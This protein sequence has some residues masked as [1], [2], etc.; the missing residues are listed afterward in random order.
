MRALVNPGTP[1][2]AATAT[3]THAVRKDIIEILDMKGCEVVYTSPDR[4]NIYYEVKR[5]TDIL[6]LS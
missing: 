6:S 4:P 1:I 5:R 3:A 2:L